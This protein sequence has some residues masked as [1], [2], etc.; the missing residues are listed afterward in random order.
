MLDLSAAFDT[1][2]HKL[3]LQRLNDRIGVNGAALEWFQ[4]YLANRF[5]SVKIGE[6]RS[7]PKLLAQGVPQ[8]S[9]LGPL[10]FTLY[11]S[12]LADLLENY[13]IMFH[14]YAD[15][16]QLYLVFSPGGVLSLENAADAGPERLT[17]YP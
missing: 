10:L 12:P 9:V 5:Q 14:G 13:E 8:G 1:I 15:D 4:S 16:T 6:S 17:P 3:L 11:T 2:D 7:D